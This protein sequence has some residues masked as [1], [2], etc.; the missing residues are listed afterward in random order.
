MNKG[1]ELL[2][3]YKLEEVKGK[4]PEIL[5]GKLTNKEVLEHLD[6]CLKNGKMFEGETVNY[7]KD[8]KP[9]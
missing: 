2:T 6:Y 3:G 4:T 8:Q 9:L 1:F 5:Q 7:T